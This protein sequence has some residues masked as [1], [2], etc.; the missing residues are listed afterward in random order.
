M[1]FGLNKI[2]FKSPVTAK[3]NEIT[4]YKFYTSFLDN[5]IDI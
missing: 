5:K 1:T 2:L 4:A 3:A